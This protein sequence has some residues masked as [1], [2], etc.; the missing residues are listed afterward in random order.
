MFVKNNSTSIIAIVLMLPLILLFQNCGTASSSNG[1]SEMSKREAHNASNGGNMG[2]SS[3][4]G[5]SGS[6]GS[7]GSGGSGTFTLPGSS[8]TTTGGGSSTSGGSSTGTSPVIKTD[9]TNCL[10][11]E[12]GIDRGIYN[13]WGGDDFSVGVMRKNL[14]LINKSILGDSPG[15]IVTFPDELHSETTTLSCDVS[16]DKLRKFFPARFF[17]QYYD[18]SRNSGNFT[19]LQCRSGQWFFAASSCKC[20]YAPPHLGGGSDR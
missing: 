3:V 10:A 8:G 16:F 20:D 11:G 12:Y 7:G 1:S 15:T 17:S 13:T 5:G 9:G 4:A 2:Y 19:T 6:S 14:P 18:C